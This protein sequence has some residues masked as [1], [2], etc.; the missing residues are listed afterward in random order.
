[1]TT[2]QPAIDAFALSDAAYILGALSP[3]DRDEYETHLEGCATC[4]TSVA[5]LAGLP[6]LMSA[7]SLEQLLEELAHLATELPFTTEL[8][9][10]AELPVTSELPFTA[11]SG[12]LTAGVALTQEAGALPESLP[13]LLARA[14]RRERMRRRL[15]V[16]AAAAAAACLIVVG[17]VAITR[18]DAPTPPPVASSAPPMPGTANLALT[19]VVRS[20]VTAS[21]RFVDMAW[22]TRIDL[23]CAYRPEGPGPARSIPYAL[24]VI[25]R[26]GAASQVAT[27]SSLPDRE[28]TVMGA[29]SRARAEIAAVEIRTLSG[30]S[31]LRLSI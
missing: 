15:A 13:P 7:V 9:F 23:T 16:G 26:S 5:E 31:I 14:V 29:S 8:P 3:G 27:W 17:T 24:F 6:A 12:R 2:G 1:M 20:P 19:A 4:A 11:E 30:R 18:P 25:D 21:A 10:P 28:L 22:G